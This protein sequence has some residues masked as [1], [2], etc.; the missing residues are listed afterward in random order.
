MIN[1][2]PKY[3][4]YF[5]R[6]LPNILW[7]LKWYILKISLRSVGTNFKVGYNSEFSDHRLIEVGNNVF[8]GLNTVINT[9]VPVK[10]G[11]NVMFGRSVTIMGGDH[12]ISQVGI[13]MR[14]VKSGGIN[15]PVIIEDDVWVGSNVTILK[16]VNLGEGCVIGA[17]SIVIKSIPPYSLCVGSPCKPVRLRFSKADLE[18]HLQKVGSK[19]NSDKIINLFTEFK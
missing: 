3:L 17:G 12:N 18:L 8:M 5:L 19:Y 7:P 15:L 11:N 2:S 4:S 1:V 13:P 14:F 6:S 16:G 9:T 10:I